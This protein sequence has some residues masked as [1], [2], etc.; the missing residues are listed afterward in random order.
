MLTE[1]QHSRHTTVRERRGTILVLPTA[2]EKPSVSSRDALLQGL[3]EFQVDYPV[4][5]V[6]LQYM[7]DMI[8]TSRE[9]AR[10]LRNRLSQAY[11]V[12][13]VSRSGKDN[14][15]P[16]YRKKLDKEVGAVGHKGMTIEEISM[17]LLVPLSWVE[18]SRRRIALKEKKKLRRQVKAF[19]RKGSGNARIAATLG[20]TL[21]RVENVASTLIEEGEI[22]KMRNRKTQEEYRVLKLLV[23]ALHEQG[24]GAKGI[25]AVLYES[26]IT[27]AN[28][29]G[30]LYRK[31]ILQPR[32]RRST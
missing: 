29:L 2:P 8:G 11:V 14:L 32:N 22:P 17:D 27:I 28:I 30:G 5:S 31:D 21:A 1:T 20:T 12:P 23:Q 13:P 6:A 10:Q 19:R 26:E 24:Y 9:R 4:G 15:P 18:A 25:A 3:I 7:A 16:Q